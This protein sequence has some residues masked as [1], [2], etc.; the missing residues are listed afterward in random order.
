MVSSC[1]ETAVADGT[2]VLFF[3]PLLIL[4]TN[5]PSCFAENASEMKLMEDDVLVGE[6]AERYTVAA[7]AFIFAVCLS[8]I[9]VGILYFAILEDALLRRFQSEGTPL[10]A[11][12]VSDQEPVFVRNLPPANN[13][14]DD[15]TAEYSAL[16]QYRITVGAGGVGGDY[17]STIIVRKQ[18]KARDAD[19]YRPKQ[20]RRQRPQQHAQ[21]PTLSADCRNQHQHHPHRVVHVHVELP[22]EEL[23]EGPPLSF[24][25]GSDAVFHEHTDTMCIDLLVL[26]PEHPNSAIPKRQVARDLMGKKWPTITLVVFLTLLTWFCANLGLSNALLFQ[27][28]DPNQQW[29]WNRVLGLS[30]ALT[31]GLLVIACVVVLYFGTDQFAAALREEYLEGGETMV[32][33]DD[34]T[35]ATMSTASLFWDE[36][37]SP[38]KNHLP[39]VGPP[40]TMVVPSKSTTVASNTGCGD[41]P[42][43][44]QVSSL[45]SMDPVTGDPSWS[46]PRPCR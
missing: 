20:Q 45:S 19:F 14:K 25:G 41:A 35:L 23:K 16:V 17:N 3:L 31:A 21:A 33:L 29:S 5:V 39:Q 18:I 36:W 38:S 27:P 24:D 8:M 1:G 12:V 4:M 15:G 44:Q 34:E 42:Y 43:L 11:K 22:T 37:A 10:Q 28:D 40:T 13:K 9:A 32:K 30:L 46:Q 7:F 6:S 26:L 2:A